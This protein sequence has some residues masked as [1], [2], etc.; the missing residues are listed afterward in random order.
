MK[1]EACVCPRYF[2]TNGAKPCFCVGMTSCS[3]N[4]ALAVQILW[5]S[6]HLHEARVTAVQLVA[7]L[8]AYVQMDLSHSPKINDLIQ[9]CV[10]GRTVAE[11]FLSALRTLEAKAGQRWV[12]RVSLS[13]NIEV[14][15]TAFGKFWVSQENKRFSDDIHRFTAKGHPCAHS[16][17]WSVVVRCLHAS[18]PCTWTMLDFYVSQTKSQT[19]RWMVRFLS[20][21]NKYIYIE[22]ER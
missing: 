1:Q 12:R 17:F 18:P 7:L 22:R 19:D 3:W 4:P 2:L 10:V 21:W 20:Y 14:D 15:A 5:V 16:G 6:C 8:C 13:G 9:N 11:H